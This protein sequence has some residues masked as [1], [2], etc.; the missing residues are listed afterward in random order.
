M[1][2]LSLVNAVREVRDA[3]QVSDGVA[4]RFLCQACETG[5]IQSRQRLWAD[6]EDEDPPNYWMGISPL[7]WHGATIDLEHHWLVLA[8]GKPMR[9]VVEINAADLRSCLKSNGAPNK[10]NVGKGPR[11][12]KLLAEMFPGGV[13]G[14]G[15]Y[16][17]KVLRADLLKLD[18]SLKP[19]DEATLKKRIEE[20]NANR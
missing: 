5:V 8:S 13:P 11:I 9:A 4:I 20:F 1:K 2:W 12:I 14:P 3:R 10:Q 6:E 19:L 17:R 16:P 15:D 18:P 7:F